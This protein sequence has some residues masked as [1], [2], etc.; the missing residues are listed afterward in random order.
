[1]ILQ[2]GLL[3]ALLEMA[4][5][6]FNITGGYYYNGTDYEDEYYNGTLS[7]VGG[8]NPHSGNVMIGG[9]P[10][11]D[12][13]WDD[14]DGTVVCRQL[15]YYGLDRVTRG[16][17]FGRV[18]E[19]FAMDDVRCSGDE[20]SLQD[21]QFNPSDNCGGEEGAGVICS[22]CPTTEFGCNSGECVPISSVCDETAD[23][24]DGSDERKDY[25]TRPSRSTVLQLLTEVLVDTNETLWNQYVPDDTDQDQ[26]GELSEREV[27]MKYH[28]Y[29]DVVFVILDKDKNG[30]IT[31][32]EI[33]GLQLDKTNLKDIWDLATVSYPLKYFYQIGDVNENRFIDREDFYLLART[34]IQGGEGRYTG[35]RVRCGP[36]W[37]YREGGYGPMPELDTEEN[38][39]C[40]EEGN[41]IWDRYGKYILIADENRDGQVSHEEI[42]D[43]AASYID[44]LFNLVDFNEDGKIRIIDFDSPKIA[45]AAIMKVVTEA[46]NAIDLDGDE[47]IN[48]GTDIP[49]G[50]GADLNEDGILNL[51][52]AYLHID[53]PYSELG[54]YLLARLSRN[55]DKN[56][57]GQVELGE[58]LN[59]VN[60]LFSI[61]DQNDDGYVGTDDVFK[62]FRDEAVVPE[63][64]V[65][66]MEAYL[67]KL[68]TFTS[69]TFK[70]IADQVLKE[71]DEN[72]NQQIS[73]EELYGA[74]VDFFRGRGFYR[75][76]LGGLP[77]MPMLSRKADDI[78]PLA[79]LAGILDDPIF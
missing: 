61:V 43:K 68:P 41:D 75:F 51:K 21:C 78:N 8:P 16:S 13:D 5:C 20:E 50:R 11:C 10:V 1:M 58:L 59:F 18:S 56:Q 55:I 15:G 29:M 3:V 67:K 72:R 36:R 76:R 24:S 28:E 48:L 32:E 65:G 69:E 66:A 26:D 35:R 38:E 54:G 46:F 53:S 49:G 71:L 33:R 57:D 40:V 70:K 37:N 30:A 45:R 79:I 77:T 23:C 2:L 27:E 34:Y 42:R 60:N 9:L 17:R 14:A 12:D 22:V 64:Q 39:A 62:I 7:L 63:D 73:R 31:R 19:S 44:T 47:S 52:D 4:S 25:C 6:Q 74:R